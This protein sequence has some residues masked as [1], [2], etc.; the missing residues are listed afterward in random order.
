VLRSADHSEKRETFNLTWDDVG[1]QDLWSGEGT[2]PVPINGLGLA[3]Y[4]QAVVDDVKPDSPAAKG[5]LQPGDT[6]SAVKYHTLDAKGAVEI[7]RWKDVLAA[8]WSFVDRALQLMG[9][10]AIEVRVNRGGQ[11]IEATLESK[12]D[13]SCPAVDRGLHFQYQTRIQQAHSVGEALEMGA[14]RTVR[15]VRGMYINL[16]AMAFGRVSAVQTMSGPI[17]LGRLAYVIAGDSTYKLILL[18]ALISINLAVVNFLPIPMLDGGHMMFLIYEGIVGRPPPDRVHFWLSMLGL[19]MV[20]SLMVFV[21]G[22]DL[23]RLAKMWFGW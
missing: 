7:S 12:P 4:V 22:L 19:A 3:Y 1:A 17:T 5:G 9:P 11:T 15:M 6:I 10:H 14:H 2:S 23:W 16:Y 21:I 13:E 18:L 20:L 8:Q